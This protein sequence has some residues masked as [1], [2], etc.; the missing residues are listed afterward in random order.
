MGMIEVQVASSLPDHPNVWTDGGLVLDQV[1]G[2][3]ASG[4]G[5]FSHSPEDCWRGNRWGHVDRVRLEGLVHS[6]RGCCSVP[7]LCNL[8]NELR[9]GVSILALLSSSAVYL[10]VDN[11]GIVRHVRRLL[12]GCP[13]STPFELVNDG[14]LLLIVCC[15]F[16]VGKRFG[17]L[18]LRVMLMGIWF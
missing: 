16:V 4:A 9:C 1:T 3:S 14:D 6:C 10:G 13:G 8:F 2:V 12:D 5:F 11:L 15:I 17:F 7:G 18:R